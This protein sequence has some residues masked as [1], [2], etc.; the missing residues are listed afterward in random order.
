MTRK[1][2]E[3]DDFDLDIIDLLMENG[4][5]SCREMAARIGGLT[6]RAIRYRMNS[7][8]EKK[9]IKPYVSPNLKAIGL[10]TIADV[11][12]DVEPGRLY[13]ISNHLATYNCVTYVGC[14]TGNNDISLQIAAKDNEDLY[15]FANQ[16][17][18]KIP[19]VINMTIAIV[20]IIV[21]MFHW[22]TKEVVRNGARAEIRSSKQ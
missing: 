4:R 9:I 14:S 22:R 18:A 6:E 17:L 7:L 5:M 16:E 2:H 10:N 11:F 19:G 20:P 21:K 1:E 8:F 13:E 3:I 15:E 12:L